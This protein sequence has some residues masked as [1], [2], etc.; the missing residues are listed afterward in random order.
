[1]GG[2]CVAAMR[3]T[4]IKLDRPAQYA[5]HTVHTGEN[6]FYRALCTVHHTPVKSA[7]LSILFTTGATNSHLL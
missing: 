5:E 7:Q 4:D 3:S 6:L 1:M 2:V